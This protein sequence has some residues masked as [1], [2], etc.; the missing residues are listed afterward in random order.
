MN[1]HQSYMVM[2]AVL[3]AALTLPEQAQAQSRNAD[4]HDLRL[5]GNNSDTSARAGIS[6]SIGDLNADGNDDMLIGASLADTSRTNAGEAYVIFGPKSGTFQAADADLVISGTRQGAQVGVSVDMTGDFDGDGYDDIV[7]G[8]SHNA[9][10]AVNAGR[11]FL[12]YGPLTVDLDDTDADATF[13]GYL[14]DQEVGGAVVSHD[15]NV[16][17]YDD[18]LIGAVGD[19][20]GGADTGAVHL[21]LGGSLAGDYTVGGPSSDADRGWLGDPGD[22]AGEDIIVLS[23]NRIIV[24]APNNSGGASLG[25]AVYV[26]PAS[27]SIYL[28]ASGDLSSVSDNTIFG[29]TAAGWFG[30]RLGNAGG[31]L[32]NFI[33]DGLLVSTI[34]AGTVYLFEG[35]D[36]EDPLE[37]AYDSDA[38]VTFTADESHGHDPV[39]SV[40]GVGD[41]S[42]DGIDDIVIGDSSAQHSVDDVGKAY[43]FYGPLTAGSLDLSDADVDFVGD[44]G[45]D[46]FGWS[47]AAG[48]MNADGMGDILVGAPNEEVTEGGGNL[49]GSAYLFYGPFNPLSGTHLLWDADTIFEGEDADDWGGYGVAAV[50]DV[51][52]DGVQDLGISALRADETSTSTGA[53]YFFFGP[54]PESDPLAWQGTVLD[55]SDADAAFYGEEGADWTGGNLD[56]VGDLDGDGCD[57]ILIP[58]TGIDITPSINVGAVYLLYGSTTFG[59]TLDYTDADAVFRGDSARDLFGRGV[60]GLGDIDD[61]DYADF[62][63]GARGDNGDQTDA[64]RAFVFYGSATRWT[65]INGASATADCIFDGEATDDEAGFAFAGP[66]SYTGDGTDFND[67]DYWDII[68]SAPGN[69]RNG[70][71]T[72]TVYV[73]FGG[74]SRCSGTTSLSS[75]DAMVLGQ[76]SCGI[77][78]GVERGQFGYS[79]AGAG[80]IDEDGYD[81]LVVG[82]PYLAHCVLPDPGGDCV[83]TDDVGAAYWVPGQS[84]TGSDTAPA[85]GEV[86]VPPNDSP[87]LLGWSVDA[88]DVTGTTSDVG[89][90]D[91][92]PEL[93]IG[94]PWFR[95]GSADDRGQVFLFNGTTVA[96]LGGSG[97][98]TDNA[99]VKIRG[100]EAYDYAGWSVAVTGDLNQ[101]GEG[102]ILI[103]AYGSDR[104]GSL[105][106]ASYVVLGSH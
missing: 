20:S 58:A 33:D 86:F 61:D 95:Y 64:G 85:G 27:S 7:V 77:G 8:A 47:V 74:A 9:T 24:G 104:G 26:L 13:T 41:V 25:G 89:D 67:D 31:V 4:S 90:G 15:L 65:G 28:P 17:G 82:A 19:S 16:D 18:L 75:A 63:I 71:D 59:G 51:N 100:E 60:S 97:E 70:T 76:E 62:A 40:A 80:D 66:V 96:G 106:G 92:I 87:V 38:L 45:D 10:G 14:L 69:D 44:D 68:I 81:D 98:T 21:F 3:V 105:S 5:Y 36:V 49:R 50:G 23:N 57:D 88:G 1:A 29:T 101:G 39:P 35:Y 11:V 32:E 34:T 102:D 43:V 2:A 94:A 22:T 52:C 91:G 48:D 56:F 6:L 30:N 42:R 83:C 72:G 12:F 46:F 54:T 93:V 78:G 103:G 84:L 99:D 73:I 37:Y 55:L 53:V 79:L